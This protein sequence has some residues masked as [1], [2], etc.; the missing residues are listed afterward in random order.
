[1]STTAPTAA[2]GPAPLGDRT[3]AMLLA[4]FQDAYRQEISAEE[5][6]HRTLPFFATALGLVIAAV[7][8]ALGQLPGWDVLVKSCPRGRGILLNHHMLACI[9][10]V[11]LATACLVVSAVL[12]IGVLADLA[13]ATRRR[14][15]KR[16]G[17]EPDQITRAQALRDYHAALGVQGAALDDAV[18]LDLREQLL[19]DLAEAVTF[20]RDL[21]LRR[22]AFRARAV[23]FLLAS[24][25]SALVA[26]IFVLIA[27]KTG[28]LLRTAP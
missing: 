14:G 3:A 25:L 27:S 9:W 23:A 4:T 8:Y 22:Y 20:N 1:M 21:T 15:Y 24:L 13:A 12:G 6:V 18:H 28:L 11:L 19:E 26:T 16:I 5:D 7:N 17:R 2:S 10:P